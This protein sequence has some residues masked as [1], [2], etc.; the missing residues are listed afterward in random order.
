MFVCGNIILSESGSG[1]QDHE[2]LSFSVTEVETH[3]Y[4]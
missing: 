1:T 4:F 2:K 3:P